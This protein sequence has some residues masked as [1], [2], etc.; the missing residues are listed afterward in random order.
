MAN[1][2]TFAENHI[3]GLL[4]APVTGATSTTTYIAPFADGGGADRIAFFLA[5]G[6]ITEEV[7][8]KLVQATD[9]AGTGS[10]DITGASIT[11]LT[12]A[13]DEK[14]VSIEIGPGALDDLNGFKYVAAV[15]TVDNSASELHTAWYVKHRLRYPGLRSQP[16]S[17]AEQVLVLG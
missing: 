9:S 14:L 17:Y 16:S 10:K 6:A 7:D 1:V 3:V 12:S 11:Q 15:I 2:H 5:V 8:M 13:T 4:V